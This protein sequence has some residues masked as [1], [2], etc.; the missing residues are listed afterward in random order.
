[1]YHPSMAYYDYAVISIMR[2]QPL[3]PSGLLLSFTVNTELKYMASSDEFYLPQ[4][5][6]EPVYW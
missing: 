4:V 6:D 1:M 3:F 2:L 5:T